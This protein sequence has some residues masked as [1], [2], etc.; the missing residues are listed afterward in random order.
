MFKIKDRILLGSICGFIPSA[1]SSIIINKT[2]NKLG[3]NDITYIPMAANLFLPKKKINSRQGNLLGFIVNCINGA[4]SSISLTYFLSATGK[5]YK[6]F[7]GIGSGAFF[8]III[9]GLFGSQL[10]KVKSS[11]SSAPTIRLLEHIST[12]ILSA[13][14][15]TKLGDESL[16]PP[17]ASKPLKRIPLIHTGISQAG[18]PPENGTN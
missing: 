16:F 9:D 3:L 12:G 2:T 11:K 15:I 4:L 18:N 5:D 14:L 8:W 7:K 17:K 10:L 13:V 6:I 1:I